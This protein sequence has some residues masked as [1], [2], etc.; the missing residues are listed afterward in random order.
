MLD[1]EELLSIQNDILQETARAIKFRSKAKWACDGERCSKYFFSL[2][3][4]RYNAKTM[5]Q[6]K[7][8]N[9]II[10]NQKEILDT[11]AGFYASLYTADPSVDFCLENESG[12]KISE[13]NKAALDK[14]IEETHCRSAIMSLKK[15]KTPGLD[16]IP[17]EFYQKFWP[18]ISDLFYQMLQQSI[19]QGK[20]CQ[21]A[22]RGVITLIPKKDRD[23]LLL[24]NW[25]PI[26]LLNT[27][28]KILA[29]ILA[30][31]LKTVLNYIISQDQT[32]FIENRQI[33]TTIRKSMDILQYC[34]KH[35]ESGYL[36]SL[37]YEKCFD[38]IS[39]S[40]ILGSL[41]YFGLGEKFIELS[42]LLLTGF[43]SCTI[44][45]GYV[46][47]YFHVG[48]SC[49]QGDPV[50]PYYFLLTGEVMALTLKANTKIHGLDIY[51]IHQILLQFADDTQLF[52]NEGET[53]CEYV[54]TLAKIQ[55]NTGLTVNYEKSSVHCIQGAPEINLEGKFKWETKWPTILGINLNHTGDVAFSEIINKMRGIATNWYYRE[56][57]L[58]G[59]I[60]IVNTLLGSLF[61]YKMFV[62]ESPKEELI[63]E[64]E[65]EVDNFLWKRKR[66][67]IKQDVLKADKTKGGIR[68]IDMRAK[69][70]SLKIFWLFVNDIFIRNYILKEIKHPIGEL[71]W[72]CNLHKSEVI[73][74]FKDLSLFWHQVLEA[75]FDVCYEDYIRDPHE[76]L[77]QILWFNS[78]IKISN[79]CLTNT[80]LLE[81]GLIYVSDLFT[82][83]GNVCRIISFEVFKE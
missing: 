44:N 69:L 40:A 70:A 53:I 48:R 24:K 29:K 20:L 28:Y 83:V 75:W 59:R 35:G 31:R 54:N 10:T 18:S 57:T 41:K 19:K 22:I 63:V 34:E 62:H 38:K 65:A 74:Y 30:D 47:N 45:N 71:L 56:L 79:K 3:K 11:Q 7:V 50:A 12:I 6:L 13:T 73:I 37:D 52:A 77:S 42:K 16:G 82:T 33:S 17:A 32:G 43:M 68:L 8:G 78:H 14:D 39:Y 80:I 72:R 2:E 9:T 36:I 46:S 49:H 4:E 25:R 60:L 55:K 64:F 51:G 15:D 26:T 61:V 67:K 58:M 81:K 21:S 23:P 1:K 76:I 66:P 27:D 5:S